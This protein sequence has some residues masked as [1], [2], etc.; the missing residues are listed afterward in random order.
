CVVCATSTNIRLSS[1][2][3]SMLSVASTS[4]HDYSVRPGVARRIACAS[5][6]EPEAVMLLRRH[7]APRLSDECIAMMANGASGRVYRFTAFNRCDHTR[8]GQWQVD[9]WT[10]AVS[11]RK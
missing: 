9:G 2:K 5:I 7:F 1:P 4:V 6:N 10:K 8:L 3:P 11:P